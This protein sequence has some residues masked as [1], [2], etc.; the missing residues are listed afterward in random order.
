MNYEYDKWDKLVT[1]DAD[2]NI[3]FTRMLAGATDYHQ[4][5]FNA[6]PVGKFVVQN[7]KPF[8]MGTRCHMLAM[9]V[10]LENYLPMVCDYPDAYTGQPGF[11][12]IKIIPGSWDET[13]VIAAELDQYVS[14][15]RRKND[16]WY[17][18]TITNNDPREITIDLKFLPVGKYEAEIYND[19][20]DA[21]EN[22][23]HLAK[24]KKIVDRNTKLNLTLAPGGGNMIIVNRLK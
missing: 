21:N 8:V 1:P 4:G 3:V 12:V 10:V 2:L 24:Q 18:G 11:D 23:N 15:A 16:K 7:I 9:Y 17:I 22:A 13:K 14:V 19:A 5:G 20:P 6:L